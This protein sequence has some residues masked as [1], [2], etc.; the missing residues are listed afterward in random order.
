MTDRKSRKSG[1]PSGVPGADAS[2]HP[3]SA[4]SGVPSSADGKRPAG[5]VPGAPRSKRSPAGVPG[6][7]GDASATAVD[8]ELESDLGDELGLRGDSMATE[9]EAARADAAQAKDT[10]ARAQAEFEN[11]RRRMETQHADAVAR[12]A[13]R[14]VE[15]LLPTLDNLE[16]AIAHTRAGG[17]LAELI[18]GVEMVHSQV[19]DVLGKEGVAV[20]DPV[21]QLFDPNIHQAVGQHE[22]TTVP[23][24]TVLEVYQKGYTMH[25]RVVRPPMVIVSSGG[26]A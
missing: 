16:R 9:L 24:H 11:A 20:L 21:G 17:D 19:L 14:L 2:Q 22:D 25:G 1:G 15:A 10:A 13:Q 8:P 18:T 6:K 12:A 3:P 23:E 7:P 26:P 4:P 5:S